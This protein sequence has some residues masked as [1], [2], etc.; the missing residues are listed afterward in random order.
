MNMPSEPCPCGSSL[1]YADCC[2]RYHAGDDSAATAEALMR[3]R[4]SAFVRQDADYLLRTWHSDTRP[5]T[6]DFQGQQPEWISL[7][8]LHREGGMADD[9]DGRVEFVA[10]YRLNDQPG[11]LHEISRFVK[12][13]DQWRYVEGMVCNNAGCGKIGRNSPCPCGSGRKYKRCCGR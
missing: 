11:Q 5:D 9:D 3:S 6:L 13:D 10:H 2:G 4:Y 12:Q 7:R 1:D 8:I